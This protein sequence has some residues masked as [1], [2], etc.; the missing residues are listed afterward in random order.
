MTDRRGLTLTGDGSHNVG[1]GGTLQ[2]V[3]VVTSRSKLPS[4]AKLDTLIVIL[5]RVDLTLEEKREAIRE[6]LIYL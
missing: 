2:R 1:P 3:T 4:D 5:E 6:W